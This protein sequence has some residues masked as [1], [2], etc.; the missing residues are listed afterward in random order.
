[1]GIFYKIDK[2]D[3]IIKKDNVIDDVNDDSMGAEFYEIGKL[4][5]NKLSNSKSRIYCNSNGI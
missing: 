3:G 2:Y 1:M 4:D 5:K